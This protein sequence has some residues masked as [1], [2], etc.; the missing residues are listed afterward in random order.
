MN[1]RIASF[2]AARSQRRL[3]SAL[4][5]LRERLSTLSAAHRRLGLAG[6]AVV[7]LGALPGT[8]L[9]AEWF[10]LFETGGACAAGVG[11][12]AVTVR[13][14]GREDVE[15]LT[16]LGRTRTEVE[17]R[18]DAGDRVCLALRQGEPVGYFWFRADSWREDDVEFVIPHGELWGYDAYVAPHARGQGIHPRM[19]TWAAE[20]LAHHRVP[21]YLSGIDYVNAPSLRSAATRGARQIGSILVM[22]VL[23]LAVLR[24]RWGEAS[25]S[26]RVYRRRRGTTVAIPA[27]DGTAG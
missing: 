21:R 4:A 3:G 13:W 27:A 16:A 20:Q 19:A 8:A 22:R 25:P 11:A 24:E 6:A 23:G 7:A 9:A 26:W 1:I 10:A 17:A 5:R 2:G 15:L 14:G 12:L 18:F